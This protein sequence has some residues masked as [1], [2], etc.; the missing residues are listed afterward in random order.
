M[1]SQFLCTSKS[2]LLLLQVFRSQSL[3]DSRGM[4][5]YAGNSRTFANSDA[6]KMSRSFL[7]STELALLVA[8][9]LTDLDIVGLRKARSKLHVR[10]H[11]RTH[12]MVYMQFTP[13]MNA[14]ASFAPLS[15]A[16]RALRANLPLSGRREWIPW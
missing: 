3:Q 15:M 12:N 9:V 11:Y 4:A 14:S 16:P 5:Y 8:G 7:P 6:R 13:S 2:V 10:L 1:A